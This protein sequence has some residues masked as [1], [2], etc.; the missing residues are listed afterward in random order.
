MQLQVED[1]EDLEEAVWVER[2]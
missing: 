1:N 2:M